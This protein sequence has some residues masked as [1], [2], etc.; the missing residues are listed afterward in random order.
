MKLESRLTIDMSKEDH[1][2][3]KMAS[4]LHG[5]TMRSFVLRSV[6][7]EI[8]LDSQHNEIASVFSQSLSDDY[9]KIDSHQIS[10]SNEFM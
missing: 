3:L 8:D 2:R 4:T 5:E 6:F 7:K 9:Q 1:L 10:N